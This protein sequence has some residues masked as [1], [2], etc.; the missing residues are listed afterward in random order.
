MPNPPVPPEDTQPDDAEPEAPRFPKLGILAGGGKLPAMLYQARIAEGGEAHMIAFPGFTDKET[1]EVT[2]R[3]HRWMDLASVGHIVTE[4]KENECTDLVMVGHIRRRISV[5]G[6][7]PDIRGATL[8][9]AI[10]KARGADAVIRIIINDLEKD[11]F[12][13]LGADEI[14]KELLGAPGA[15][16]SISPGAEH[17]PDI[18]VAGAAALE[19]GATDQGQAAVARG[20]AVIGLEG[21]GGTDSLLWEVTPED[22]QQT[23]LAEAAAA[24]EAE[25]LPEAAGEGG[26]EEAPSEHAAAEGEPGADE[27]EAL[28]DADSGDAPETEAEAKA[29]PGEGDLPEAPPTPEEDVPEPEAEA[30][31]LS[32]VL[33]KRPKPQQE[34]RADLPAIGPQTV[35]AARR[36]GLAGIAIEAG[37][38]LIIGKSAT[39][40]AADEAGL[41]LYCFEPGE[42]DTPA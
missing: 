26:A 9:P 12:H 2:G 23:A 4:L 7:K 35:W 3:R 17:W 28:V 25:L 34:R 1:V 16:G 27:G 13:V 32:G 22:V 19:L 8:L 18:H 31:A 10:A 15:L 5:H 21:E 38:T 30:V 20:G 41:F 40:D 33:V 24:A 37:G 14:M 42:L 6:L 29:S 39:A 11:G 36:A